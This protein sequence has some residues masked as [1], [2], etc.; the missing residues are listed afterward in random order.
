MAT[1]AGVS[2]ILGGFFTIGLI[3]D[4]VRLGLLGG[5]AAIAVVGLSFALL[6]TPQ[7]FAPKAFRDQG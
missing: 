1:T 5:A 6:G 2:T 7:S 3:V 4:Q